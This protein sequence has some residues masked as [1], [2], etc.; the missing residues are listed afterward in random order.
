MVRLV[1]VCGA[2]FLCLAFAPAVGAAVSQPSFTVALLSTNGSGCPP[3]RSLWP[4]DGPSR[5]ERQGPIGYCHG[6]AILR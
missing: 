6:V 2:L 3:L 5:T 4:G 1:A